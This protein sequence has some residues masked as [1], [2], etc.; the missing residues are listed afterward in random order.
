[1]RQ[2]S[3]LYRRIFFIAEMNRVLL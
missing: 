1:M 2:F 3:M